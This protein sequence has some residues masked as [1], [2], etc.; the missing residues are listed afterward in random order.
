MFSSSSPSVSSTLLFS[1]SSSSYPYSFF[2]SP[3]SIIFPLFL[4]CVSSS[5][6][7][8]YVA[9]VEF[10]NY[11][12]NKV[13]LHDDGYKI[14]RSLRCYHLRFLPKMHPNSCSVGPHLRKKYLLWGKR[15]NSF[16]FDKFVPIINTHWCCEKMNENTCWRDLKPLLFEQSPL[17]SFSLTIFY[18]SI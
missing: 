14:F 17:S 13:T 2:F 15:N 8:S 16:S 4:V 10:M 18:W 1:P 5:V 12:Q 3:S 11:P 9:C 7:S 6:C